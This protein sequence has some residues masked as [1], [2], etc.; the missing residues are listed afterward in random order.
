MCLL[1][2]PLP[3]VS[4]RLPLSASFRRQTCLVNPFGFQ[5]YEQEMLLLHW[6]NLTFQSCLKYW[7]GTKTVSK[8]FL[9]INYIIPKQL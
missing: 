6:T 5:N 7:R 2:T 9:K 8:L 3:S 1:L 4:F